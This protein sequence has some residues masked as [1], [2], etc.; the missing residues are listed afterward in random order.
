MP[1]PRRR[2]ARPPPIGAARRR[3]PASWDVLD[4]R[5]ITL[6]WPPASRRRFLW[7]VTA[8]SS[9]HLSSLTSYTL[10]CIFVHS[11]TVLYCNDCHFCTY[12]AAAS[13]VPHDV[14]QLIISMKRRLRNLSTYCHLS[15]HTVFIDLRWHLKVIPIFFGIASMRHV[16]TVTLPGW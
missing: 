11:M 13:A 3:P 12:R 4:Q 16:A 14:L 5:W 15:N 2:P 10:L 1:P 6:A 8:D 7:V 9:C